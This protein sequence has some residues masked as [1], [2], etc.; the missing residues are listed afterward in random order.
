M[1]RYGI[2]QEMLTVL[3]RFG[4]NI[5]DACMRNFLGEMEIKGTID[6]LGTV[7]ITVKIGEDGNAETME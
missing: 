4:A 2:F 6:G 3:R 5:T 7:V 1:G